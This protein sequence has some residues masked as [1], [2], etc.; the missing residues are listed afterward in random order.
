MKGIASSPSGG[1]MRFTAQEEYGLRCLL[2][3]A[4][5]PA[6]SLTIPEIAEREALTPAYVAKLMRVLRKAGLVM[7]TRGQK[8][9]YRLACPP[10]QMD[11]GMVLAA[12]GGRLYSNDFCGRYVG[13]EQVCVHS[14]DCSI[15]PLWIALDSVVQRALSRTMLTDLLRSEQA[16][17]A[18]VQVHIVAA[19]AVGTRSGYPP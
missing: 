8:G 15:R 1:A 2:Q 17:H 7:S 3:I 19:P 14:G 9:G 16:L 5:E 12:L 6:G 11:L 18:W 10:D 4:R 13:T